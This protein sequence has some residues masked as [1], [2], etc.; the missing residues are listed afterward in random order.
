MERIDTPFVLDAVLLLV[1]LLG[2]IGGLWRGIRRE[3][4]VSMGLLL[5]YALAVSWAN[6]WSADLRDVWSISADRAHFV[7][8]AAFVAVPMLVVGVLGPRAAEH[9]PPEFAGRVGGALLAIVNLLVAATLVGR[10]A[11]QDLLGPA[12]ERDVRATR[13]VGRVTD[14][15]G[16]VMLGA[17]GAGLILL[18]ASLWVKGRRRSQFRQATPLRASDARVHRREQPALAPEAEKVEPRTTGL[19]GWGSRA[20][21]RPSDAAA[22]VPIPVVN[23]TSRAN[24][25]RTANGLGDHP[26]SEWLTVTRSE[27]RGESIARCLSCGERLTESDRFCPRC[28]RSLN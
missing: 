6:P 22:T 15:L 24:G 3:I 2:S 19:G 4:Y 26:T 23:D 10:W 21:T 27:S 16:L 28:G 13:I 12:D 17:A 25:G 7:V 5:G 20:S 18:L 8:T 9:R 14:E 1:L 11:R